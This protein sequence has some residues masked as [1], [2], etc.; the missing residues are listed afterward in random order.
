MQAF[1]REGLGKYAY[2]LLHGVF[3][4]CVFQYVNASCHL[5]TG[6]INGY[7]L[8]IPDIV[9]GVLGQNGDKTCLSNKFQQCV[10]FIEFDM[11]AVGLTEYVYSSAWDFHLSASSPALKATSANVAPCFANGLEINGRL[12]QSPA[13]KPY[14]GAFG[15]K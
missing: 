10:Y 8:H 1:D 7:C 5:V 6:D 3:S 9:Y 4:I 14:Y 15:T 12:Y 2:K 11:N 13:L